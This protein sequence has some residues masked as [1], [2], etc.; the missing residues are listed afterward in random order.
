MGRPSKPD[1]LPGLEEEKGEPNRNF[2]SSW[3]RWRDAIAEFPEANSQL[4][5]AERPRSLDYSCS[6]RLGKQ[7][8]SSRFAYHIKLFLSGKI[9]HQWSSHASRTRFKDIND[10]PSFN[11]QTSDCFTSDRT[12]SVSWRCRLLTYLDSTTCDWLRSKLFNSL[13]LSGFTRRMGRVITP[14]FSGLLLNIPQTYY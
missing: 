14:I 9:L 2:I 6:F 11:S 4:S 5:T 7:R 8:N 12:R 10:C 13:S 1:R 3:T